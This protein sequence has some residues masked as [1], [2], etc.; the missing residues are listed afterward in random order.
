MSAPRPV[1]HRTASTTT[2]EVPSSFSADTV[3]TTTS[4]GRMTRSGARD[5]TRAPRYTPGMLPTSSDAVSA[6]WKSPTSR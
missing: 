4:T 5:E 2:F 6:S 3:N 1:P